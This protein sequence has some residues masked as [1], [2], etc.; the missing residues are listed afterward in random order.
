MTK[1]LFILDYLQLKV[2]KIIFYSRNFTRRSHWRTK[3]G[4][5][6]KNAFSEKPRHQLTDLY[7]NPD[8][9]GKSAIFSNYFSIFT[10]STKIVTLSNLRGNNSFLSE[11]DRR[12]RPGGR[13]WASKLLLSVAM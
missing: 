12:K 10:P 3:P 9:P 2:I 7:R 6:R 5:G 4:S 11:T 8:M 13:Y 1:L